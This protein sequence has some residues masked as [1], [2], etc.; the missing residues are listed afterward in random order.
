[1]KPEYKDALLK[2][3]RETFNFFKHADRDHDQTLHVGDI[4]L[5]NVL[6][7]GVCIY[8]F[9]GLSNEFT[10]HMRLGVAIARLVFPNSFVNDDQRSSHHQTINGL[11]EFTLREFLSAVRANVVSANFPNLA[12]ERQAD[13]QDV[14]ALLDR[15]FSKI[16]E[17]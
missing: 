16:K 12:T 5:S 15:P 11:G 13:L 8:N 3:H 14:N 6:Q 10:D 2:V 4:A 7:L 9:F 17:D 1:M